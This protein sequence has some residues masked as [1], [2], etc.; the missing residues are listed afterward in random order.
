MTHDP[1]RVF[2]K[3]PLS[4]AHAEDGEQSLPEI[5]ALTTVDWMRFREMYP[6]VDHPRLL[7]RLAR[8]RERPSVA[9]TLPG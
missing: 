8:W 5:A 4:A 2:L 3:Y 9:G 6:V 7:E 1:L